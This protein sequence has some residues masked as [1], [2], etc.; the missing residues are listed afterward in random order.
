VDLAEQGQGKMQRMAGQKRI[1]EGP[2]AEARPTGNQQP[3]REPAVGAHSQVRLN[4]DGACQHVLADD[5]HTEDQGS[6]ESPARQVV[7]AQE[8]VGGHDAH[9]RQQQTEVYHRDRQVAALGLLVWRLPNCGIDVA[10]LLDRDR[11]T[12]GGGPEATQ[13]RIDRQRNDSE[14]GNLP[15]GIEAA[16]VDK[17]HI[18]DVA[19]AAFRQG[20]HK[21]KVAEAGRCGEHKGSI[22]ESGH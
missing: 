5:G 4:P 3:V 7:A 13:Q 1:A 20:T 18:D 6:D 16:K 15:Q 9:E 21:E 14:D 17:Q 10:R 2:G 11:N 19:A 12:F 8:K 22:A